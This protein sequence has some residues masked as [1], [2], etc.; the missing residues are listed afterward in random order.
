MIIL[1]ILLVI[2]L[3]A[4]FGLYNARVVE[5]PAPGDEPIDRGCDSDM[6]ES[7]EGNPVYTPL[8]EFDI[9]GYFGRQRRAA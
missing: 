2:F 6:S 1:D 4:G 7:V 8:S 5:I 3:V 9:E